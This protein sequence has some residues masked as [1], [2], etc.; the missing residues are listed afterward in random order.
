MRPSKL[1][2]DAAEEDTKKSP[3]PPDVAIA[4]EPHHPSG[5]VV[6]IVGTERGD[7]GRSCEEHLNCGE[8]M[9][10]DVIVRLRK[11]QVLVD[12][13]EETAIACYWVTDGVDRCRVGFLM[14]HMVKHAARY[15]GALAQVTRV[16]SDDEKECSREERRMFH[17]KR[18]FCYATII[19]CLP[20]MK[21]HLL[22]AE[23][24]DDKKAAIWS[25]VE[26]KPKWENV[27]TMGENEGGLAKRFRASMLLRRVNA[28]MTLLLTVTTRSI[29]IIK[30]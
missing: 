21:S 16:F 4:K 17:A 18:G 19:S 13:C 5:V 23:E 22:S 1:L 28:M 24:V 9:A 2:R 7:Q 12:G 11:V 30:L 15:D 8:V 10:E 29:L 26:K 27:T 20:E 25:V 3:P 14:R 6:E